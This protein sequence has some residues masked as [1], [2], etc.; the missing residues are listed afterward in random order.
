MTTDQVMT[1]QNLSVEYPTPERT[2]FAVND[3]SFEI[4][5]GEILG[6]IGESG[7]GKTTAA[8]AILRLLERPGRVA[9]GQ[10]WLNGETELLSLPEHE[11]RQLRWSELALVSQG[12]MNSLN[13]TMRVR[14][15]I[16][17]GIRAH[18]TNPA[19][20]T[21]RA[22]QAR[23]HELLTMVGLPDRVYRVYPHELS[24]GMKQRVGI[25]MAV[26]L[27]PALVIADEPTSALDVITQRVVAQTL[28]DIRDRLGISVLL[29]G[30]DIALMAQLA[31]RIAVMYDGHI[32]EAGPVT[33]VLKSPAHPYTRML[34]DSMPSLLE[35]KP[36][37]VVDEAAKLEF[38][39][40]LKPPLR[41]VE[42]APGHRVAQ[43]D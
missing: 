4:K 32:V 2:V 22:L 13:P 9:G 37:V 17:D 1:I 5:R 25:A 18:E 43:F 42:V 35:R 38:S 31:D 6:L 12:A 40:Y 23:I 3:I 21:K 26:A 34:M 14:D 24:G 27:S 29:I 20:L 39:H 28:L 15:Q 19:A 16:A 33:E 7:S 8:N 36:L 10:V 30:H 41:F 11:F